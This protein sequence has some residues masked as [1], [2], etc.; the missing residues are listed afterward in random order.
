VPLN[1]IV[2]AT[3]DDERDV[4][5]AV[6]ESLRERAGHVQVLRD[7]EGRPRAAGLAEGGLSISH[8]DGLTLV[9]IDPCGAIGVD[10]EAL[11]A[12]SEIEELAE[13]YLPADRVAAQRVGSR[14]D[15]LGWVALWTELEACAK[16]T[17]EGLGDLDPERAARLLAVPHVARTFAVGS[18]H[19]AT[20]AHSPGARRIRFLD[21]RRTQSVAA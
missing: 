8:R 3:L 11:A 20:L 18:E 4:S 19:L 16:L 7:G 9:A 2:V 6:A 12:G 10:V 5:R 21:L 14:T 13:T 15:R 17:G 1:A